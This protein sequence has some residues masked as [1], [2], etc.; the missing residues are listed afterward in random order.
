MRRNCAS[1]LKLSI[2][3]GV[4]ITITFLFVRTLNNLL[5]E[6]ETNSIE[7]SRHVDHP[8]SGAFFGG[9]KKNVNQKLIDWHDYEYQAKEGLRKGLGE[10]GRPASLPIELTEEK[11]KMYRQNGFNALL[12]DKISV[13]RSVPDIR[14]PK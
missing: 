6:D 11:N 7:E 12:S 9:S 1:A 2:L 8:R 3:L 5:P 4:T 13:N 10:M 14:H